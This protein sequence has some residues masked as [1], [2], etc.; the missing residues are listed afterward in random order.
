MRAK[1]KLETAT[2]EQS[3]F[4]SRGKSEGQQESSLRRKNQKLGAEE[5]SL[6]SNKRVVS[7]EMR[8]AREMGIAAEE[9]N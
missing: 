1:E 5:S 2:I 7:R 4:E 3:S 8:I 9:S 6:R